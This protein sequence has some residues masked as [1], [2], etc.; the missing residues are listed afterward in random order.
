[1]TNTELATGL[2]EFADL[3]ERHPETP[4]AH[5]WTTLSLYRPVRSTGL[6]TYRRAVKALSDGGEV[7]YKTICSTAY[8]NYHCAVRTFTGGFRVE[9]WGPKIVRG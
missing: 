4:M 1:M 5:E 7:D 9:L 3:L 6:N 2:R 8:P